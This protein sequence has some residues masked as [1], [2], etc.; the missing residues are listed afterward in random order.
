[1]L[2]APGDVCMDLG[3]GVHS[4]GAS[5]YVKYITCFVFLLLFTP[6]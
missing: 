3:T 1:M 2:E 6:A 4:Y 5:H